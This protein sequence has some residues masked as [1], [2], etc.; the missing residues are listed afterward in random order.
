VQR[1]VRRRRCPRLH[2]SMPRAR[3]LPSLLAAGG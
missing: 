3:P 2:R 1:K